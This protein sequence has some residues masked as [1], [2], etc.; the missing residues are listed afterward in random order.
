MTSERPKVSPEQ[1]FGYESAD[2]AE[3]KSASKVVAD[4]HAGAHALVEFQLADADETVFGLV[5]LLANFQHRRSQAADASLDALA[6]AVAGDNS[7]EDVAG[8][9]GGHDPDRVDAVDR[10]ALDKPGLAHK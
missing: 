3:P 8:E 1:T 10:S 5:E 7:R 9:R 4:D 6:R 2:P